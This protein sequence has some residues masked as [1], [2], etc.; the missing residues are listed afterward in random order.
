[1]SVEESR[2]M[3]AAVEVAGGSAQLTIYPDA[4]HDCW[5]RAYAEPELLRWM[6]AQRRAP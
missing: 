6:V 3:V 5:N 4:G 2:S 1:V